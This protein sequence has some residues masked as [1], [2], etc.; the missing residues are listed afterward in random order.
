M[1]LALGILHGVKVK[2]NYTELSLALIVYLFADHYILRSHWFAVQQCLFGG[3]FALG[4]YVHQSQSH[5]R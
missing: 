2:C 3:S 1:L 4:P 5:R